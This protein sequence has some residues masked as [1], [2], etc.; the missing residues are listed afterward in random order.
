MK[1]ILDDIQSGRFADEGM[2]ENRVGET[3]FKAMRLASLLS[4]GRPPWTFASDDLMQ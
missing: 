2:L 1:C 3:S 4:H